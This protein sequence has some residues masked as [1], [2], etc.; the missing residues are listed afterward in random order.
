M[1]RPLVIGL[2]V[3]FPNFGRADVASDGERLRRAGKYA[4]AEKLLAPVVQRDPHAFAARLSLGLVYRAT[5]RRDL[6]RAVWNRFYDDF[7]SGAIDK[8]KARELMY[9]AEAARYLGGWQDANDTFRDAVD[10]DPKGKDG[11]RANVEWAALFLEKYDA[12]HA[13]QSLQEALKVLPKDP[14]AHALYARVKMEQNDLAG[15]EREVQAALATDPK[16]VAALDARADRQATDEAWSEALAT[17]RRALAVNPEDVPARI[18][19]GGV[20]YLRGDTRGYEAERDHVLATNPRAWELFHGVAEMCVRE[21]RYV[22]ANALEE[23]AL[24]IEPKSWVALAAIGNNWLRLGEDQKGL[25][26]LQ[27]A[28]KRDPY[29]VRTYNLLQLFEDVIPKEYVLVDGTPFRFRVTKREEPVLL[30][31]VKP[32]VAREYAE[33]VKRYGFTPEGPLTIELYANPEHYAVRTVGLP[34]LEALG[35][36]F[37]KVVTGMSPAGGRFNWGLMLW[38]E[39]A[40]IFSIQMSKARVPRWFTE[41]LSEYETARLDP[42]WTRRTHAELAHAVNEG[43]LLPVADL[44]LG[45]TRARDVSHMVVTYHQAAEEVMFLVRRFGFDVVP[46]ALRL[47]A[48]GKETVEVIPAIT[49]MPLKAYDAAFAADLRARLKPYENN[50]YVRNA[51]ISDVE[52]LRDQIAAHPNDERAKGLMAMALL[53][54]QQG[55]EAQKLIEKAAAHP[56]SPE[57]YL[58]AGEIFM[59]RKER[60]MAKHMFELLIQ[61]KH[62]GYDA[63]LWLGKIAADEGNLVEAKKQLALA[64]GYD[65]DS[66]EPYVILAK[67][68]L[69][70]EPATAVAALEKAAQ[71]EV[72][73]SSIPKTLVEIYA[74]DER[75]ADVVRTARLSQFIDPYDIDVHAQLARALYA[76]GKPAEAKAEIELALQCS[77]NEEQTAMLKKLRA[78][79]GKAAPAVTP[80]AGPKAVAPRPPSPR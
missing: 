22:E 68:T 62:D 53:K 63:R 58:A 73:D 70:A 8:K 28:W 48:D 36:T 54:A 12:G 30:H 65:P 11:A 15:A 60:V 24:K 35:V 67:A 44:N 26:A 38:H 47:F 71:L 16:N 50:F 6:E 79:G 40:H 10:A 51:D 4:E 19:V 29:N 23:Q 9:V 46:K 57:T 45:F 59:A 74:K 33:L 77:P 42:T 21:H 18:V 3:L 78:T 31:Y 41:G 34:G 14:E 75:W 61:E 66:A 1:W 55:E 72:M 5:G 2:V 56:T 39:V 17:A 69:K 52:A 64:E 27:E 76:T 49:G 80:G 25:A 13:E 37:G 32:F 7:E 43:K 20:D